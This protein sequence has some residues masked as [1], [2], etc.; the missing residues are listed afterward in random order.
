MITVTNMIL[1]ENTAWGAHE[2]LLE[3]REYGQ[4]GQHVYLS[5]LRACG[6][7]LGILYLTATVSWQGLRVFTDYW[8]SEWTEHRGDQ[9]LSPSILCTSMILHQGWIQHFF[10]GGANL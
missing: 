4:I 10:E 3:E 6:I 9:V 1:G 5:Y 8:L 2:T 7:L